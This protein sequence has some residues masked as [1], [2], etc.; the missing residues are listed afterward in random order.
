MEKFHLSY[1]DLPFDMSFR[2]LILDKGLRNNDVRA[3]LRPEWQGGRVSEWSTRKF[4]LDT[5]LKSSN[6]P[7]LLFRVPV[8]PPSVAELAIPEADS[9]CPVIFQAVSAMITEY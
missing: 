9:G 7:S 6:G 2:I 3:A 5:V 4:R 1:Q 8:P